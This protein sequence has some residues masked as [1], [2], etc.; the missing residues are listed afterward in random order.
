MILPVGLAA[1]SRPGCCGSAL[2]TRPLVER[3]RFLIGFGLA[4]RP[5]FRNTSRNPKKSTVVL[6]TGTEREHA[7]SSTTG[8]MVEVMWL[9]C[10]I[11]A[12]EGL[13]PHGPTTG[14]VPCRLPAR[15]MGGPSQTPTFLCEQMAARRGSVP[16]PSSEDNSEFN[17]NGSK[18]KSPP[19]MSCSHFYVYI[20]YIYLGSCIPSLSSLPAGVARLLA[21][22]NFG[23]AGAV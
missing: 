4:M 20:L 6:K 19:N 13:P 22:P 17:K 8:Q 15:W 7:K 9:K 16:R 10:S 12:L 5:P 2:A 14:M 23:S 3:E 18:S 11:F 21:W 1:T